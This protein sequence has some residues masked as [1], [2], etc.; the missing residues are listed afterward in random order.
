MYISLEETTKN[1]KLKKGRSI[2]FKLTFS[3]SFVV[4]KC[5]RGIFFNKQK[6]YLIK[7][8]FYYLIKDFILLKQGHI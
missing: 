3:N 1:G 2:F 7:D 6:N 8:V 4:E 5:Y